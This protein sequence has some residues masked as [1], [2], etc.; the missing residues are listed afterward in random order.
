MES[1]RARCAARQATRYS[2]PKRDNLIMMRARDRV[3]HEH[4]DVRKAVGKT[5]DQGTQ[6]SVAWLEAINENEGFCSNI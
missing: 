6:L 5:G 1:R 2:Q 4:D 3:E